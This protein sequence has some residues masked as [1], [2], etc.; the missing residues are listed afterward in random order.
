M[1]LTKPEFGDLV[2]KITGEHSLTQVSMA[3]GIS[4][5]YIRRMQMGHVP[6]RKI[7]EQFV[8]GMR[9]K[10][11]DERDLLIIAGYKEPVSVEEAVDF[12]LRS[13]GV[14]NP[15]KRQ[16]IMDLIRLELKED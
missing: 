4:P 14:V 16:K 2:I 5:E 6:S 13:K 12:A 8:E 11:R 3:T 15:K 9:V 10:D 7:I 1:N